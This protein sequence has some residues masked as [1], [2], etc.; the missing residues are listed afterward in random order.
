MAMPVGRRSR[1]A[2]TVGVTLLTVILVA[3]ALAAAASPPD[4]R[5]D[6]RPILA[7]H[8]LRCHG[9][10]AAE[11]AAELR[12][13]RRDDA[14][15]LLPSGHRAV[16]PGE[17]GLSEVVRR[18]NSADPDQIMPPPEAKRPLSESQ[19]QVLRRW[20]EH[21]AP[22]T[23]HWSFQPVRRT[24]APII[25]TPTSDSPIDAIVQARLSKAGWTPAAEADR[26]TLI[27]RLALDL[28]GLPPT[29]AEVREF[30][31]DAGPD[32]Y[33][34]LVDRFL[35]SPRYGEKMAQ[36]WLDLARF[37]DSSGYQDDGDRPS[38][39]Y[40]DY[41]I[42]AFND[43]MPFGRFTIENL[44]GDL[45]PHP[46]I[47][48]QVASGFNRLHRHNEEGGSDEDEFRV[49][50]TVDRVN[51]TAATWLGLTFGCAQCHDH[52]YDPFT[53]REYYSFFAFFNSLDGEVVINKNNR[54]CHPFVR[55]PT[56]DE[57]RQ[58]DEY[59]AGITALEQ[60]IAPL[61]LEAE[62]A[63]AAWVEEQTALVAAVPKAGG[64]TAPPA[65]DA[66]LT[67][68]QVLALA[69]D[70]RTN[71]HRATLRAHYFKQQY[72]VL[73]ALERQLTEVR[74]QSTTFEKRLPV[75]LVWR[76]M[77]SPRP[78]HILARGDWQ[79]PGEPV[80]RDVP[81]IFPPLAAGAARDRLALAQ[82]LVAREH[83]LT[84]RV[85]ANR[86]WQQ[87]FGAG[88]VRTPED[89]G[90]RGELPTHPELLDW[91]AADLME[92]EWEI[93]RLQREILVSQTYRQTSAV[94]PEH[95][96]A[97][98]EN[99]LLARGA[100]FRLTAEE[101]RDVA[102][103]ASGLLVEQLG[104]E[105]VYP[106]QNLEYYR[107]KED[108]PGEWQW[109]QES[110]PQLYRRGMY[111]FWRR[112]TPYPPF[113]TFD[114]PSR[115]ECTIVRSRTNTPLQALVTLNDPTYVE[116]ARVLG[117]RV[118]VEGGPDVVSRISFV[119]EQCLSRPPTQTESGV[120]QRLYERELERYH[121]DTA[122]A[123]ALIAHGSAAHGL[124]VDP[125]ETAAWIT[126]ATA[127]LNL[128]ET[129]SRE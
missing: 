37:G 55:V 2:W 115:G 81:S 93:K 15:A 86:V 106:Y 89:F 54:E 10:D 119:F 71:A 118:M 88:L 25:V 1:C 77:P 21:Q 82:W 6:I 74:N 92:D 4:F 113:T 100:R 12:L 90:T 114:A 129:I 30:V 101:V 80:E 63:L 34:R 72:P 112:T 103:A 8:C 47:E 97:D 67:V 62:A 39:P 49:V 108:S 50:Y 83:P 64:D 73:A 122:A 3:G 29:P 116:A 117:E 125:T 32:A 91:L 5:R 79:Q 94:S 99:R 68:E 65:K 16:V 11:R 61:L 124:A 42:R 84:S 121:T 56:A 96:Q 53:Q 109:P 27:R 76:E 95:W 43:G 58:Q 23:D 69:A 78:A 44:A 75:A 9:P 18:I 36:G 66:V 26:H 107:E 45:L 7:E 14:L 70:Q 123:A 127:I 57:Q 35:A 105:S 87:L 126:V 110:G 48:Q 120:M 128:D 20:I 41:V 46:T 52:K 38:W 85:T 60:E 28:T 104:G 51:T 19:K 33:M 17:P 98:P 111:T 22:Y 40:R 31:A 102:L 59:A 13:D 24:I